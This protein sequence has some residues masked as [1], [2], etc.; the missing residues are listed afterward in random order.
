[1]ISEKRLLKQDAEPS[2][3]TLKK[4]QLNGNSSRQEAPKVLKRTFDQL[5]ED[6]LAFNWK[7]LDIAVSYFQLERQYCVV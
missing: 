2:V 5:D 1:L 3:S 7:G 4:V 6:R